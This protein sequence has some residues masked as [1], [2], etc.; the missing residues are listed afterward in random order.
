M[1]LCKTTLIL[2]NYNAILA[3]SDCEIWY[4]FCLFTIL[5]YV[6]VHEKTLKQFKWN[7]VIQKLISNGKFLSPAVWIVHLRWP[8]SRC[9]WANTQWRINTVLLISSMLLAK[10]TSKLKVHVLHLF[11]DYRDVLARDEP[12]RTCCGPLP[13]W[14]SKIKTFE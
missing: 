11:G 2:L 14:T 7:P 9:L 12:M 8:P 13:S 5:Q 1:V 3:I 4:I 6:N 10:S